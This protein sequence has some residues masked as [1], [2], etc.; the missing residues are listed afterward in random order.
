MSLNAN[1]LTVPIT[2]TNAQGSVVTSTSTQAGVIFPPGGGSQPSGNGPLPPGATVTT[3]TSTDSNGATTVYPET[4]VLTTAT[5]SGG[6][7]YTGTFTEGPGPTNTQTP[8][9][10]LTTYTTF[11]SGVSWS[12]TSVASNTHDL[13]G[14]PVLGP[15][16]H[17]WFCPPGSNGIVLFGIG[18][19]VYPREV[20]HYYVEVVESHR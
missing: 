3:V 20:P 13:H 18:P 4:L 9:P 15:W 7:V 2:I 6:Q 12:S 17:C 19:G 14:H 8:D 5:D 1:N 10:T 16:P 11:P